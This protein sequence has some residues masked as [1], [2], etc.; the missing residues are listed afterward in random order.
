MWPD[1]SHLLMPSASVLADCLMS[2]RA[3]CC[4]RLHVS[5]CRVPI[6]VAFSRHYPPTCLH[7][8]LPVMIGLDSPRTPGGCQ[9]DIVPF[10]AEVLKN[11]R[12]AWNAATQTCKWINP[13]YF[14]CIQVQDI[15]QHVGSLDETFKRVGTSS[16]REVGT[17]SRRKR[18]RSSWTCI[19]KR[20]KTY[21]PDNIQNN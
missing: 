21:W 20:Q 9:Q 10:P 18:A 3:P 8:L 5:L 12:P 15:E 13:D 19:Q 17:R 6:E 14:I 16:L 4:L 1:R 2:P 11:K 7:L